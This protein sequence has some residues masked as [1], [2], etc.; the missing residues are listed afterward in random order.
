MY[1]N[2]EIQR[3]SVTDMEAIK[4]EIRIKELVEQINY[5][6]YSY[7]VLDSPKISDY[8]YDTLMKELIDLELEY[9]VYKYPDSP[10]QKV[11][12]EVSK[13]FTEVTH[14]SPKL[15]LS[16]VFDEGDIRSFD[17]RIKRTLGVKDVEYVVELK[18]DGLTVVLIYENG[19]L[20]QGATRGDGIRGEDV[21]SNLKTVRTIPLRLREPDSLE[22]RG[23]V[24]I[25][26]ADFEKLNEY[27]EETEEPPFANPRNAAA[28]SLRQLDSSL[29]A[30][31]PLDIFVFSMEN[32]D[33]N[34]FSSHIEA[35]KY[36]KKMGLKISPYLTI[37]KD[38]TEI[39]EQCKL[40]ADKRG[41]LPFEIDGLVIKVNNFRYREILGSTV[42]APRWSAAYKFPPEKKKTIVM[43]IEVQVGRTGVLTP[44]AIL[45]PVRIAGSVVSRATLHNEDNIKEKDIRIG[46]R[47]IL[48]KAGDII[49]EI[50]EV[51]VAERTGAEKLFKM[52]ENCPV[53]G[54]D[55]IRLEG[56]A[57]IRCTNNSCPAQLRRALF[58]FVSR[59]AMNIDG[60]GP[61]IISMLLD[62]SF[63]KDAADLY[64]LKNKR[65][66]L[67]KIERMGEKSVDNMLKAIDNSKNN[68]LGRLIFALGIRMTGQKASKLLADAF[69]NINRLIDA[70]YEELVSVKE[71]GDKTAQSIIS[72]FKEERNINLIEK[73]K[74]FGVNMESEKAIIIENTHFKD[75]TFVLTGTLSS[76]K[77]DEA[78]EIIESYGGKVSGSVSKKT[79]YVLAGED[80]GSKLSKANELGIDIIDEDIFKE[81]MERR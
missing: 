3:E 42:K 30:K 25:P 31:R 12:G 74:S 50:V 80:A 66:D 73:L 28:G 36:L 40:W 71:I 35:M 38:W 33:N 69:G 6:D 59:D 21:T 72:F 32:T 62:N 19:L 10:T 20:K 14:S 77:R 75:K 53:C 46:D 5:H 17:E 65:E 29:T 64:I 56:E 54:A 26:K 34:R 24:F 78:K 45:E 44:T 68:S 11:G 51:I 41:E 16:N 18:I 2:E 27:R 81:W 23:E 48:Q 22:V 13:G 37:C 57:A 67:I 55:A 60:L 63:I 79:N 76:F 7:Y 52:P 61:Q 4:A 43:D 1:V 15:S 47:V 39:W 70:T 49:P 9:P 58:H 8:E